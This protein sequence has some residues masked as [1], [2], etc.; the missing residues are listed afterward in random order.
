MPVFQDKELIRVKTGRFPAA[1]DY[2]VAELNP[3]NLTDTIPL[4]GCREID[5]F[6]DIRQLGTATEM[7]VRFRFSGETAPVI[8]TIADWGYL[9][10]DNI[11]PLTGISTVQDYEIVFT[12]EARR[13][14]FRITQTSGTWVSC[15]VWVDQG[16]GTDG[17]VFFVRQGGT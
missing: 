7:H 11:D 9:M 6:L 14:L 1:A 16:L 10:V 4:Y 5:C 12:P 2:T 13:Y 15:V 17:N 3:F 8:G